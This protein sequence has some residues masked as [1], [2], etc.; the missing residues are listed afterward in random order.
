METPAIATG[1]DNTATDANAQTPPSAAAAASPAPAAPLAPEQSGPAESP[2]ATKEPASLLGGEDKADKPAERGA[3]ADPAATGPEFEATFP[4]GVR[5][6]QEA[7]GFVKDSVKAGDLKPELAQKLLDQHLA[8]VNR[9]EEARLAE[10]FKTI[11]GWQNEIRSHPEFGGARLES[12]LE[13]A[14]LMLH[15]YGSPRLVSDFRRMGVID[16]PDFAF[17]LMRMGRELSE[18]TSLGGAGQATPEASAE[19]IYPTM[20]GRK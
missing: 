8:A 12:S 17:M 11:E 5:V 14:K 4:D 18:G 20:A 16:H 1:Q 19:A 6:D 3:E 7:M 9:Y 10:G 2:P 13:S 15:K